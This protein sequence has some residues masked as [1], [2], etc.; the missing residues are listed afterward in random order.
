MGWLLPS[1][2]FLSFFKYG[3]LFSRCARMHAR[4]LRKKES[5]RSFEKSARAMS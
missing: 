3:Y 2:S 1:S 4:S 5:V